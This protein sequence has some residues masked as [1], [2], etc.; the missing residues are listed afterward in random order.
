MA[1]QSVIIGGDINIHV[2]DPTDG[3]NNGINLMELLSS[4]DLQQHVTL[5]TQQAGGILIFVIS[6][7]MIC[8]LSHRK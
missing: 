8:A 1:A 2:E 4:V 3:R 6:M 7:L 5:P